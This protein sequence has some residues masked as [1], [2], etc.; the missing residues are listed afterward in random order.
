M[1]KQLDTFKP[2]HL[3]ASSITPFSYWAFPN[4][5]VWLY[6]PCGLRKLVMLGFQVLAR[7]SWRGPKSIK[8]AARLDFMSVS[9]PN[10]PA[11]NEAGVCF[12]YSLFRCRAGEAPFSVLHFRNS[13]KNYLYRSTFVDFSSNFKRVMHLATVGAILWTLLCGQSCLRG[14]EACAAVTAVRHQREADL[15]VH[16]LGVGQ[17]EEACMS[18]HFHMRAC[19]HVLHWH[20][21]LACTE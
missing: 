11:L 18:V 7:A 16:F 15:S 5:A 17:W 20:E 12:G 10:R 9:T 19:L 1:L 21:Q 8:T 4:I 2:K 14:L 6:F 13:T 3:Q